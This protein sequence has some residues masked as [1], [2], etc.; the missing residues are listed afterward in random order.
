MAWVSVLVSMASKAPTT[1]FCLCVEL[2][3]VL[4]VCL[5]F[6]NGETKSADL[7]FEVFQAGRGLFLSACQAL[8]LSVCSCHLVGVVGTTLASKRF[9]KLH[10]GATWGSTQAF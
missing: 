4:F 1:A 2:W 10:Q 5:S 3:S 7:F 9:M 6:L 8:L